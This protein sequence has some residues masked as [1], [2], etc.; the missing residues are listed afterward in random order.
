MGGGQDLLSMFIQMNED[1]DAENK[2][3]DEQLLQETVSLFQGGFDTSSGTLSWV[4]YLLLRH[5][6][7]VQKLL[8]EY[9]S[10]LGSASAST[11]TVSQL[12]YT[13]HVIQ[14][15][16][17]LYPSAT[18]VARMAVEKDTIDGIEIPEKALVYTSF[19]AVHRRPD[20][21]ESPLEFRPERFEKEEAVSH[22]FAYIPFAAGPRMCIGDQFALFEM[23][24]TIAALLRRYQFTLDPAYVL[25]VNEDSNYFP[26]TLPV[27][28][29]K[30]DAIKPE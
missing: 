3:T 2:L 17:R 12:N 13:H 28:I 22:Q 4:F 5:P 1:D 10:V 7:I 20:F 25:Q 30:R 6:Q 29:E 21:W 23:R 15:T 24:L 16:M 26:R 14:E 8:A 11:E 27:R 18:G 9:D 19:Y